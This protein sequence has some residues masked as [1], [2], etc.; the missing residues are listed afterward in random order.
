MK[1]FHWK[2]KL[3]PG[4]LARLSLVWQVIWNVALWEKRSSRFSSFLIHL[5]A[6]KES[7]I[8][9]INIFAKAELLQREDSLWSREDHPKWENMA[10]FTIVLRT[11]KCSTFEFSGTSLL[12]Y[13]KHA[14]CKCCLLCNHVPKTPVNQECVEPTVVQATN[15][16]LRQAIY[17]IWVLLGIL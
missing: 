1:C 12:A 9:S 5:L 11:P 6:R 13:I 8:A 2:W 4:L 16:A 3:A 7:A 14:W 15:V 17:F 10:I